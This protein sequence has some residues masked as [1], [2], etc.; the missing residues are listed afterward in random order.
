MHAHDPCDGNLDAIVQTAVFGD[1]D[2]DRDAHRANAPVEM[3]DTL[4]VQA[5]LARSRV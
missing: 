3:P 5:L 1:N 2:P 4:F